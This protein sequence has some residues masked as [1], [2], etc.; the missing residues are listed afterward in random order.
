MGQYSPLP[1]DDL[2]KMFSR[3]LTRVGDQG[4]IT[5]IVLNSGVKP[6]DMAKS[7]GRYNF[8]SLSH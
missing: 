5:K 6:H 8:V 4:M 2:V 3:V 1:G 7:F